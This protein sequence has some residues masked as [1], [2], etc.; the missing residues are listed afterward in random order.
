MEAGCSSETFVTIYQTYNQEDHNINLLSCYRSGYLILLLCIMLKMKSFIKNVFQYGN[1]KLW[2][3]LIAYFPF[4][5][6]CVFDTT[7]TV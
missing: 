6:Y 1:M 5:I 2:K 4:T 7:Q 3:E